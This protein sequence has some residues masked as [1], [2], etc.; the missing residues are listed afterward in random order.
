MLRRLIGGD[1]RLAWSLPPDP[2]LVAITPTQID[3]ILVNLCL[4][5]RDAMPL[6]GKIR[7]ETHKIQ[8]D[9]EDCRTRPELNP[10][11]HVVLSVAD[12]GTGMDRNTLARLFEPFFTTKGIGKGT[13]LGLPTVHGTVRQLRGIIEVDSEPG[14]GTV[15]RIFFPRVKIDSPIE[16]QRDMGVAGWPPGIMNALPA[17]KGE[18][19]LI[20]DEDPGLRRLAADILTNLGYMVLEAHGSE[21]AEKLAHEHEGDIH[22]ILS[23]DET[24]GGNQGLTQR[25]AAKRRTPEH[26]GHGDDFTDHGT[27][28]AAV[29]GA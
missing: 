25:R 1:I 28:H 24:E 17:A 13:G 7:I 29:C 6:G 10:G 16:E 27:L 20:I 21:S 15:F 3:Q 14:K 2:W 5:A 22:L 19:V 23:N 9:A 12:T 8:L 11:D 18:T 4:N 26:V